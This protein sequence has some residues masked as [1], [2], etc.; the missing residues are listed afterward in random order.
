LEEYVVK[1]AVIGVTGQLGEDICEKFGAAGHE[2]VPLTHENVEVADS[3][4]VGEVL[5]A[6][7]PGLVINTSA[8][9]HVE[10]REGQDKL[11]RNLRPTIYPVLSSVPSPPPN[12]E[13]GTVP[14]SRKRGQATTPWEWSR[15]A[16][17]R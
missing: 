3:E 6:A 14:I 8:M 2:L 16:G 17:S 1:V 11:E 10:R 12:H 9:H 13:M 15:P 4:M 7:A 5:G